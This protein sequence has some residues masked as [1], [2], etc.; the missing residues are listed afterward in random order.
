M[1]GKRARSFAP[2]FRRHLTNQRTDAVAMSVLEP[3]EVA[4]IEMWPYWGNPGGDVLD[5]AE[6]TVYCQALARSKF[7][8][9][10]NEVAPGKTKKIKLPPSVRTRIVAGE[11]QPEREHPDIR[12]ARRAR[13]MAN[14]ARVISERRVKPGIRRTLWAQAQRLEALARERLGG[15]E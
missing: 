13:T 11:S 14:L 12:M 6:Y 9:V 7:G 3:F 1:S 15:F 10:L 2:A 4:A 5:R 8:V